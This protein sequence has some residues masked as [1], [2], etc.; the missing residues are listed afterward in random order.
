M[1]NEDT[2]HESQTP[3]PTIEACIEATHDRASEFITDVRT[4]LPFEDITQAFKAESKTIRANN[5]RVSR[6][7]TEKGTIDV[8]ASYSPFYGL[9]MYTKLTITTP[10]GELRVISENE[11]LMFESEYR[12]DPEK[13]TH[14]V[15]THGSFMKYDPY[16]EGPAVHVGGYQENPDAGIAQAI[17]EFASR[18]DDQKMTDDMIKIIAMHNQSDWGED[19]YLTDPLEATAYAN[20]RFLQLEAAVTDITGEDW[21]TRG[22]AV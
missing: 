1:A 13:P 5:L 7:Q 21:R 18:P 22:L 9:G 6:F 2:P 4:L 14:V 3:K 17:A 15:L 11:E 16:I 20:D 8:E 10:A 19:K 12:P